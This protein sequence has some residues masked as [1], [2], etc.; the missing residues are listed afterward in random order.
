M[1]L[2][3]AK[4]NY[5]FIYYLLCRLASGEGIVTLGVR[6]CVCVCVRRVESRLH[7]AL[8]STAKVMRGIQ[9]SVV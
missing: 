7:A 2:S 4:S 1:Y 6:L 9:C 3:A 8:V 5:Q